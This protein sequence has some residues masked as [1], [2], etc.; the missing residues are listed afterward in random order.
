MDKNKSVVIERQIDT[1]TLCEKNDLRFF[2]APIKNSQAGRHTSRFH[3]IK[4]NQIVK[5]DL[6][7]VFCLH[8]IN[9]SAVILAPLQIWK[10]IS[11]DEYNCIKFTRHSIIE[12][13]GIGE[14]AYDR[15]AGFVGAE[16]QSDL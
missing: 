6:L 3:E 12:V 11:V 16:F 2:R 4:W 7:I 5:G 10:V 9:D 14:N 15:V 1:C 8:N 13:D